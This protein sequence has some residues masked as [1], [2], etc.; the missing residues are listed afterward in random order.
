MHCMRSSAELEAEYLTCREPTSVCGQQ[1][2]SASCQLLDCLTIAVTALSDTLIPLAIVPPVTIVVV[3][4]LPIP[5]PGPTSGLVP[6]FPPVIAVTVAV[7]TT[8]VS[9][10]LTVPLRFAF[11]VLTAVLV[12]SSGRGVMTRA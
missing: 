6:V 4:S 10:L 11:T 1:T 12:P 9:A 5:V 2:L 8:A 7:S 3:A